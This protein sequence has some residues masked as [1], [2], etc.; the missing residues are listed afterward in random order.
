MPRTVA[1]FLVAVSALLTAR[2]IDPSAQPGAPIVIPAKFDTATEHLLIPLTIGGREFWCNPDTGFSAL[3]ALDRAKAV[4]AGLRVAPGIPTPDGNPPSAGDSST[5]ATV[6]VGGVEF[7]DH[8]VILRNLPEEAPDTD[9]I[10]GV[11]VLRRFVVEFEQLIP[12]LVLYE[13][14]TYRPREGADPVPL[15]FRS[16]PNVPYV[17]LQLRLTKDS[18]LPL[19]LVPDTGAAF[20]GAA[21]VG[22]AVGR[23]QSQLFTVAAL[24][25]SDSRVTQ[26]VAARPAAIRVGKSIVERPIIALVQGSLGGGA[27]ADGLLGS[28][29]FRKFTVAFDFDGRMMYLTPNKQLNQPHLLE[30]TGIGF[31]R[32]GGQHVVFRVLA[33]SA[34]AAAGVVVGDTLLEI[35]G[36]TASKLTPIQ[37]RD[38]LSVDGAT[39]RLVLERDGQRITVE[40]RLKS[41]I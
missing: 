14:A 24:A 10:I 4:A 7:A 18:L 39:R 6:V 9:C 19:R 8:P 16:N 13:R 2:A 23:V 15:V 22:D 27:I 26:L 11:A 37:V 31:I 41:R 34:G 12:R 3:I 20:Y 29:F 40:I 30:A 21:L 17:D 5:T 33:G 25:H 1:V 28:G 32:R 35:D 36:L 38:L